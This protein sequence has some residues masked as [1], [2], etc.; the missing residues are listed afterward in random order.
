MIV[1]PLATPKIYDYY[2]LSPDDVRDLRDSIMEH[3]KGLHTE[4]ANAFLGVCIDMARERTRLYVIPATWTAWTGLG[5]EVVVRRIR[6]YDS[7]RVRKVDGN[8]L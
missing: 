1:K 2:F 8:G 4:R 3:G 7:K 6:N 5:G